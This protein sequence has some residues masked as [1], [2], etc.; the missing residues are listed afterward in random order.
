M[1][2]DDAAVQVADYDAPDA[3]AT[4]EDQTHSDHPVLT[5]TVRQPIHKLLGVVPRPTSIQDAQQLQCAPS[6]VPLG[7]GPPPAMLLGYGPPPA[8]PQ[9]QQH[10][11]AAPASLS[12]FLSAFQASRPDQQGQQQSSTAGPIAESVEEAGIYSQLQ[13][14]IEQLDAQK[15]LEAKLNGQGRDDEEEEGGSR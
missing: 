7:Y 13:A 5:P 14:E 9:S 12:D 10:P 1:L 8:M 3:K 4:P 6:T 2:A 11:S 15:R